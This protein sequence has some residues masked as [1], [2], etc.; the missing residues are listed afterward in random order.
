MERRSAMMATDQ[1]T[2]FMER[3]QAKTTPAFV[4]AK[5]SLHDNG[6]AV[7]AGVLSPGEVADLRQALDQVIATDR[8]NGV[9]MQ[10]FA[11]DRDALNTRVVMLP[12]KHAQFRELAE[13]PTAL[14]LVYD[15]LGDRIHLTSLTANIT[16][17]GS[18]KMLMHCDQ[19]YIPSPWPPFPLGLNVGYALDDFTVENGATLFVPGSH[20]ELHAPYPDGE[21][22]QVK[23]IVAKA[24]S[25]LVME[26]RLWHQ[27][28]ANVTAG[29]TR[30]GLFA[31]YT[32]SFL[33]PQEN[34]RTAMSAELQAS[35]SPL[36][37]YIFGLDSHPA[38]LVHSPHRA[39]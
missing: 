39:I 14:A 5:Q 38:R 9:R 12:A 3:P 24:G 15:M 1:A 30:I 2:G 11:A 10:G 20:H 29:A 28:G 23:P 8:A 16:A 18:A 25:M 4:A 31:H 26:D 27:T 7:I 17:P 33:N 32:R 13:N 37:R 6:M 21:Y 36:Q 35:L 22:P 34:W 19:G